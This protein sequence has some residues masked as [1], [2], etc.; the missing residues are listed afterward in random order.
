M[1]FNPLKSVEAHMYFNYV[2]SSFWNNEIFQLIIQLVRYTL[3]T[4]KVTILRK[5]LS[6]AA[7]EVILTT[8]GTT[9]NK[10]FVPD[11]ICKCNTGAL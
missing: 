7:L 10:D 1:K 4:K 2:E 11:I 9:S 8:S 6:L 5:L 3:K